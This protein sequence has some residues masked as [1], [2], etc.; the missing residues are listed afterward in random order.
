VR[1]TAYD[2]EIRMGTCGYHYKHWRGFFSNGVP[3]NKVL[4]F[5]SRFDPVVL[6]SFHRLPAE[7]AFDDWRRT[8]PKDFVVAVKASRFLT[9]QEKLKDPDSTLEKLLRRASWLS[10]KL[11]PILFQLPPRWQANG[12]NLEALLEAFPRDLR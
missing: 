5:Y 10:G 2:V 9:H 4:D 6:D 11:G 3:A 12:D 8:T 7:A 1:H